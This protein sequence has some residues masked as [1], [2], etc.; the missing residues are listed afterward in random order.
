MGHGHVS[1]PESLTERALQLPWD[2]PRTPATRPAPE[3]LAVQLGAPVVTG[4][5]EDALVV[6]AFA[7]VL[8]RHSG[9]ATIPLVVTRAGRTRMLELAAANATCRDLLACFAEEPRGEARP[10]GKAGAAITWLD[11]GS[12]GGPRADLH[13]EIE[14]MDR[15]VFVYD[16]SLF[17]RSTIERLAGHLGGMVETIGAR[18]DTPILELPLLAAPESA[19]LD[20]I[21]RGRRRAMSAL[22]VHQAFE[23]RAAQSPAAIALRHRDRELAYDQLNRRAN[24]LAHHLAARGLG[25][26]DRVVVCV[27]PS[28][29]IAVALLGILKAGA[30]YVPLDPTYPAAR[31]RAILEDTRPALI[32]SNGYLIE[33]LELGGAP[34]LALDGGQLDAVPDGNLELAID[35]ART[36]YIYYTSGTTGKPKG[37]LASH[38]NLRFYLDVARERYAIDHREVM[39][40]IA[41][42]SF[43]ISM[44]ELASPLAAGGTLIILDR[45]HVLD[46]ERMARTLTEVTFFHAGPSLLKHLLPYIER[47][48]TDVSRFARVRH[49]SSGGDMVPPEVLEALKR[50][51]T[52]AEVFVIYGC[53]EISCM[54]CTYP[55]SREVTV[56][57]TY[58]GRPFDNVIVRVLN[59]AQRPMP[60]GAVGEIHFAGDGIVKGYLDRPELTAEKFVEI[61]GH[62]FY[63]TGDM[64]RVSDDGWLEILGRNDFQIKVRGMRIELGEVEHHLRRA[65]GVRDAAVMAKPDPGGDKVM[66]GYLVFGDGAAADRAARLAA[67]RRHM[68]DTV[69]DY[70]VPVMYVELASLPLNHNLKLDRHALPDPDL[71]AERAGRAPRTRAPET[72]TEQRLAAIWQAVIG[73]TPIG[74]DDNFFELGADSLL[75]MKMIVRVEREL[76]VRIEGMDVLRESLEVIAAICDRRSR[77]AVVKRERPRASSGPGVEIFHFDGLYGVLHGDGPADD[78][79]VICSPIGQEAV[80]ARFVLSKVARSLAARGTPALLFDYYGL[81]DSAGD[82]IDATPARWQRDIATARGELARRTRATRVAALGVRLGAALL[83]TAGIDAARLVL[84]DPVCRGA[85]WYDEQVTLHRRCLAGQQHLRRGR[86]PAPIPGGEEQLGVIYSNM[87]LRDLRQLEVRRIDGIPIRWLA[88]HDTARQA[89]QCAAIAAAT[90]RQFEAIDFDCAWR[91]VARLE[92]IVPDLGIVRKLVELVAAP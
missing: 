61:D 4:I 84:W 10:P 20:A 83:A 73:I 58:V 89:Q 54:G 46:P 86:R 77:T 51:F 70:M 42:F 72:P 66:V 57:K 80:R 16:A 27:E 23:A 5:H 92:D 1:E 17:K 41:R 7:I 85:D 45:D 36:A 68:A 24:Q 30:V 29:D 79:V 56:D 32:V 81:G 64:G 69:P 13:L 6:A 21:S 60:I 43:S 38:A 9:Q 53:S 52:A 34:T 40:A 28:L 37:I 74:L 14:R 33:Q 91:D 76:R 22:L 3:R 31:I 88:T 75:A 26:E 78:A 2:F 55:V 87:A 71:A 49:A 59:P 63:R 62:R 15:A 25:A 39:P 44:F 8:H 12:N 67:V 35:P 90:G 82:S 48:G 18:L 65:P 11:A 50:I 19:S 47:Q